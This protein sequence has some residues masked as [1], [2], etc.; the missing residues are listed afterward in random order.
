MAYNMTLDEYQT[1]AE[2]TVKKTPDYTQERQYLDLTLGLA[3]E[4]GEAA[5]Y[6][7]KCIFHGHDMDRTKLA[8]ELGDCLWY[9]AT[10]A[11][12]AGFYLSN[13]AG[14]NIEKLKRRYP[15]GFS[16]ERSRERTE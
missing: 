3:G 16:E 6:I 4:A 14:G 2:R 13:I 1:L 8:E 7:K 12:T 15:D 10:L 9:I 5:N 11:E